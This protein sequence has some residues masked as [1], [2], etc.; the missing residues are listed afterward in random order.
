MDAHCTVCKDRKG[1]QYNIRLPSSISGY[2]VTVR[3]YVCLCVAYQNIRLMLLH[4]VLVTFV[5][6]Q[7]DTAARHAHPESNCQNTSKQLPY[8][9]VPAVAQ[10]YSTQPECDVYGLEPMC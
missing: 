1:F 8:P 7:C 3:M 5:H 4:S 9:C 6:A 2:S 10:E